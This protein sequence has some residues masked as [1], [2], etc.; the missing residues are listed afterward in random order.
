MSIRSVEEGGVGFPACITGHVTGVSASRRYIIWGST[1]NG[2][3][4]GELGT[5]PGCDYMGHGGF[6]RHPRDMWDTMGYGPHVGSIHSTAMLSCLLELLKGAVADPGFPLWGAPT[7][8]FAKFHENCMKSKE[9]RHVGVNPCA[10][11]GSAS[12]MNHAR[13]SSYETNK[14]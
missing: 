9:F 12:E 5:Y 2:S 14:I 13:E 6:H 11:L 3:A 8:G 1:F 10:L 7:Y 4:F